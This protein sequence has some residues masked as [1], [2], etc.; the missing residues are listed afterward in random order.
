MHIQ[1]ILILLM[2]LLLTSGKGCIEPP[3]INASIRAESQE[4]GITSRMQRARQL[5][6]TNPCNQWR[7]VGVTLGEKHTFD[8]VFKVSFKLRFIL[9]WLH[10]TKALP[11]LMTRLSWRHETSSST[12]RKSI[13]NSTIELGDRITHEHSRLCWYSSGQPGENKNLGV[14]P[15]INVPP[16]APEKTK[17]VINCELR[18]YSKVFTKFEQD[19]RGRILGELTWFYSRQGTR[20][21]NGHPLNEEAFPSNH[22]IRFKLKSYSAAWTSNWVG[23]SQTAELTQK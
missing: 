14:S 22:S 19:L 23:Q 5:S 8:S 18:S 21:L 6:P 12:S 10:L 17:I 7:Q 3:A 4:H 16:H 1:H 2:D 13:L 20:A 9:K 11:S 15:V